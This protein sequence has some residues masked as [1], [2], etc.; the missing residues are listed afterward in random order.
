MHALV[1]CWQVNGVRLNSLKHLLSLVES[2]SEK[3]LRFDLEPHDELV[4]LEAE[5]I[6]A[7]TK[8]LL[9]SHSIPADR[10]DDLKAEGAGIHVPRMRP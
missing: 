8:E 1:R 7:V 9:R 10:S 2:N 3:M 4:V 6:A 5:A